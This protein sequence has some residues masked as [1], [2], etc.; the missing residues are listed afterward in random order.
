MMGCAN[1]TF[2]MCDA[3]KN[4]FVSEDEAKACFGQSPDFNEDDK[5]KALE[6]FKN[7]EKSSSKGEIRVNGK[8]M[9]VFSE[10]LNQTEFCKGE[11]EFN[12]WNMTKFF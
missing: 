9:K 12:A 10:G 4:G 6:I 5:K 11:Q 8:V 1:K 2:M 7:I 3:D